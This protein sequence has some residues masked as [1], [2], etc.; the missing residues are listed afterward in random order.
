[1]FHTRLSLLAKKQ[2]QTN[3]FSLPKS[4]NSNQHLTNPKIVNTL[5]LPI[6]S[7]GRFHSRG[8]NKSTGRKPKADN[9]LRP[10]LVILDPGAFALTLGRTFPLNKSLI[11]IRQTFLGSGLINSGWVEQT[12]LGTSHRDV[13]TLYLFQTLR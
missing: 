10:I 3:S 5:N 11:C 6:L 1:M 9:K 7:L 4:Q 8:P 12:F 2:Q 13:K